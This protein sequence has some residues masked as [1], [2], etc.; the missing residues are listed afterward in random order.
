MQNLQSLSQL[1]ADWQ[2][3]ADKVMPLIERLGLERLNECDHAALRVN[4]VAAAEKLKAEFAQCGEI[5]SENIINGR[6]ILIIRLQQPLRLGQWQIPCV[7]LPF[8]SDK[9]YPEEGWEHLE[10]V[11]PGGAQ[12]CDEL[13]EQ[14]RTLCP[15]TQAALDGDTEIKLK[16]SS[17]KGEAERLA[18]PTLAFKAGG[19]C[20]KVHPHSIQAIIASEQE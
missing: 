10:L 11:L 3:F 8:P 7:E 20:V 19:V 9:H 16:A 6:P 13:A 15:R 2:A 18:N 5:I 14:L 4:S 17:P 1:L 12:S